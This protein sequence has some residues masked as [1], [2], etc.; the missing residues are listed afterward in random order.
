MNGKRRAQLRRAANGLSAIFQIG[1]AG[2]DNAVLEAI[3]GALAAR[4]LIKISVLEN[5]DYTAREAAEEVCEA[6][7]AEPVQVIGSK[8]VIYRRNEETDSYP[9]E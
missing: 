4:E 8:F 2:I 1:K 6:L 7:E 9:E 3:E 5:S